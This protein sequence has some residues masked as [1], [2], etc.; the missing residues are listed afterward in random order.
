[1][2]R[3]PLVGQGLLIIDAYDHTQTLGR[4][5]LDEWSARHTDFY[6]THNTH[7]RQTSMP[8]AAF[9]PAIPASE[10]PKAHG[11]DG[12]ATGIGHLRQ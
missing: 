5:P 3:Q 6:Q 10:R 11:L 8:S 4:I 1:M 7:N 12:V 2:A 9:E